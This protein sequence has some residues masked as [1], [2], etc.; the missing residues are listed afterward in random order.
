MRE[1]DKLT[2]RAKDQVLGCMVGGAVGDA[3]GYAVEFEEYRTIVKKY[4]VKGITR[5][6]LDRRGLAEI[7]DDTQM[8]L[9]TAAGILLGMTRSYMRGIMGRIDYYCRFTYLD[10]L[11]TQEW[12]SRHKD[13]RVDSW[14]MDVPGLYERRAPGNTCLSAL[15][16][17]EDGN[18][19]RN[20]SCGCGGVMRTAPLALLNQLH[21]YA[22]GDKLYCD[23]CA[24]EAAR[25]T[26]KH[27]LGFIPSAILNDMLMQILEG[28]ED[29]TP[30]PEF[31]VEKAL[32]RL[33]EIVSEE[34]KSRMYGELWPEEIK[35]QKRIISKALDLAYSDI[36][37]HFAIESIG[38]GWTGH[39]ALAIAI[40]SATKHQNSFEDAIISSVNH[41]GDSDSTG[42]ICGNIMGC[43]MGRNAIPAHFTEHLELLNV[44]E[45]MATDL[46]TGCVISEYDHYGTPE[47][48]RWDKKYCCQHWEPL[49]D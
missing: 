27:P 16:S 13:A 25:I 44:I 11:H 7:S 22:D 34:D 37:D 38:G 18:E 14:L 2:P 3:L 15:H 6:Q 21:G 17:I 40:Y 31:F 26:H 9:F 36:S 24:A 42:A 43:L 39:E 12:T 23:M 19:A 30:R 46:F 5:Y 48:E 41:S 32:Q 33:P 1:N 47:K 49:K 35:K 28:I 4:G 10:W 20:N 8:S 45:E 29:K